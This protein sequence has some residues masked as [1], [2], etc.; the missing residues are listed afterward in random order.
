METPRPRKVYRCIWYPN[1]PEKLRG[2]P[3]ERTRTEC[4]RMIR[5]GLLV[6]API[7]FE[8][9][10][11]VGHYGR[12]VRAYW[13]PSGQNNAMADFVLD[14]TAGGNELQALISEEKVYQNVSLGDTVRYF[15]DECEPG[16]EF[17]VRHLA[18]SLDP[19]RPGALICNASKYVDDGG[20]VSEW[21]KLL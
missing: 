16:R 3:K 14:D 5:A 17:Q 9:D 6:N 19:Y 4:D 12:V 2:N 1:P 20:Q 13:D 10:G 21:A 8:H 7:E 15:E 11:F 18:I